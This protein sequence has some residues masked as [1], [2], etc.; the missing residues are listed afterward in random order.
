[1]LKSPFFIFV[2]QK[3]IFMQYSKYQR[4]TSFFI[5][6]FFLFSTTFRIPLDQIDVYAENNS[7][8]NIVSI[9]VEEK[10]YDSLK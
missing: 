4:F 8:K 5:L 3:I 7:T 10:A 1:M 9:I 2:S 6:F